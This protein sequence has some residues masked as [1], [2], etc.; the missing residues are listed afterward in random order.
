MQIG[1][2]PLITRGIRFQAKVVAMWLAYH[3][4]R[5]ATRLTMGGLVHPLLNLHTHI[6]YIYIYRYSSPRVMITH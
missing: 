1:V 4:T 3:R 5:K 6:I 2:D